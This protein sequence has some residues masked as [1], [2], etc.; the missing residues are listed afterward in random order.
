MNTVSSVMAYDYPSEKL[1]V[2]LSDDAASEI[3]FYDLLEAS[4]AKHWLPPSAR[5]STLNPGPLLLILTLCRPSLL[6]MTLFGPKSWHILRNCTKIWKDEPKMRQ[7]WENGIAFRL[8]VT[9]I[10]L[11]F[12]YYFKEKRQRIQ[13]I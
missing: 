3:T 2:Y 8:D 9:I 4:F 6:Q 1:N 11:F 5:D 12:R 7:S 13:K 10:L